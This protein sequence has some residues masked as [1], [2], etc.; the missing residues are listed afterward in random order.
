VSSVLALIARDEQETLPRCLDSAAPLVDRILVIDTGSRDE[1]IRVARE[2][3]AEVLERPWRN[4]EHNRSE[5]LAEASQRCE[6]ILMLDADMRIDEGGELP[7]DEADC[8]MARLAY[9]GLRYRLPFLI[10]SSRPWR[11]RGAA[12]SYLDCPE[13]ATRVNTDTFTV[14]HFG[15]GATREKLERDLELLQGDAQPRSIFYLAQTYRDLGMVDEAIRHYRARA[16]LGGWDEEV[17]YSLYQ[18]GCLLCKHRSFASGAPLLLE[19]W[20]MRP[21]RAEPLRALSAASSGVADKIPYPDDTLF[22][23]DGAYR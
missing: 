7:A 6:R 12:H 11:Y 21:S 18:A 4:F 13:P 16:A 8:Y 2:H 17:F 1:T 23:H 14:T 3:G 20:K 5:L 22:V 10:R 15:P 19:A 9:K